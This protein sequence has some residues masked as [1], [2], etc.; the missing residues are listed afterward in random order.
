M[1]TRTDLQPILIGAAQQTWRERDTSRT[2]SDALEW[3]IRSAL[4]DSG[5]PELGNRVDAV[6]QI[7]Y[8]MN[9]VPELSELVPR[10]SAMEAAVRLGVHAQH[11]TSDVGGNLPQQMLE[12][13]A[14]RL[15]QSEHSMVV[16]C[17]VELL[18]TFLHAMR[19]GDSVAAWSTGELPEPKVLGNTAPMISDVEKAHG[20]WEP[21]NTY[22]LFESSLAAAQGLNRTAHRQLLGQLTESMSEVAAA[23]PYAWKRQRFSA[24]QVLDTA[25]GNRL[26]CDPYTKLMNAIIGVDQAAAVVLTTVGRARELGVDSSHW[27]YLW[28]AASASDSGT[29][30]ERPS[31]CDSD[32]IRQA[33]KMALEQAGV[34][35]QSI[36]DFDLYSCFPSA[37][38][39]AC[40]ALGLDPLDERR[41]T[42]TGGL[43]LFGGPGNNYSLHAIAEMV[44]RLRK[45]AD[46]IGLVT[47]NGGYLSKHAVGVY[48]SKAPDALWTGLD[49]GK[50][51]AQ[52][53]QTPRVPCAER[54]EGVYTIEAHTV[55]YGS[56]GP[57]R[58][59]LLGRLSTDERCVAISDDHET[60]SALIEENCVGRR[61]NVV[62]RDGLNHVLLR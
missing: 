49:N 20:L 8:V 26:I 43:T 16:L 42:V 60:I 11:F 48:G 17:G 7:P 30:S 40:R 9:Q 33:G 31:L 14:R 59:I 51:Q 46:G 58:A 15:Q 35:L 21:V 62:S 24:E 37:V 41:V 45:R 54:G 2:P 1:S 4:E 5:V 47:A 44:D 56:S 10:N 18:G 12:Q 36:T 39:V 52:V 28:G 13:F 19:N 23:N 22:P 57:E 6:V 61:A 50:I 38:Q 34:T 29:I 55:R 32:A 25:D 3:V 27:V 53:D